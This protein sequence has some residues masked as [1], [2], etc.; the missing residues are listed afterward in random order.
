M[1][2]GDAR[3]IQNRGG[4]GSRTPKNSLIGAGAGSEKFVNRGGGGSGSQK[5]FEIGVGAGR[6]RRKFAESGQG[7]A[8]R[9]HYNFQN[10]DHYSS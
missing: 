6:G 8:G 4:G 10:V 1:R 3:K 2:G 7:R 9:G 5:N